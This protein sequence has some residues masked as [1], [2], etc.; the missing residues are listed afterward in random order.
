MT[1]DASLYRVRL[2]DGREFGPVAISKIKAWAGEGRV[3]ANASIV[4]DET[5][6]V[7]PVGE[8]PELAITLAAPPTVPGALS[9]SAGA[10]ASAPGIIP[11]TNGPALAS[12]YV[13]VGSIVCFVGLLAAPVAVILGIIGLRKVKRDPSVKG[14]AH[15]IVGIILGSLSIIAHG[16][17]MYGMAQL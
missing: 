2:A 4:N 15:A 6:E 13:G 17:V 1:E 10:R 8:V 12:Y 5:G 3:P 11:Y 16:I 14:T 7:R 9:R